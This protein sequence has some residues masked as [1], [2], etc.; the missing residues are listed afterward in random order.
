MDNA[1]R[2]ER[3]NHLLDTALIHQEYGGHATPLNGEYRNF[4]MDAWDCG[5]GACLLGSY[6]LTGYGKRFF[7]WGGG[8]DFRE[9]LLPEDSSG[10]PCEDAAEHFGIDNEE[11]HYLFNPAEYDN[12]DHPI[13]PQHAVA[14]VHE[15]IA[16]YN[17]DFNVQGVVSGRWSSG[18]AHEQS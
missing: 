6:A 3:L 13:E 16:K 2:L 18:E 9:P 15:I 5:T 7:E 12:H 11:A 14:R 10:D 1:T 4:H 8:G 17:D